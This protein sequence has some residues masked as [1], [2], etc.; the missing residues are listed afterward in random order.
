VQLT[1]HHGLGNDFLIGFVAEQP[2]NAS[3]LARQLCHRTEGIG[4]DGLVLLVPHTEADARMVLHNA[5]GSRAEISGNGLRC[6]GQA[7]AIDGG[8]DAAS[9]VVMT[10][11]GPRLVAVEPGAGVLTAMVDAEMGEVTAI[12]PPPRDAEELAASLVDAQRVG[13]GAIGNPH[14]VVEVT[15]PSAIDLALVGPV[16]EHAVPSG[17]NVEFIAASGDDSIDL[18]AWERGSGI[19]QA[20]GSGACVGAVLAN[21]WGLT[22]TRVRVGMP[23]G[24]ATVEVGPTVHLIGPATLVARIEVPDV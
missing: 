22:G 21:R 9:F 19:T 10:D 8:V 1:K 24:S 18:T 15:D 11:A 16:V 7:L 3:D 14:I 17:T 4:A 5:D 23:G 6:V 12:D 20:C 13:S 2:S